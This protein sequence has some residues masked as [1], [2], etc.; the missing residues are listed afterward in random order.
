MASFQVSEN[1]AD[2]R[3]VR[4]Q[5]CQAGNRPRCSRLRGCH[6]LRA[7]R[8]KLWAEARIP[9]VLVTV[10]LQ[11]TSLAIS[12]PLSLSTKLIYATLV[13]VMC[14]GALRSRQSAHAG[15]EIC[16]TPILGLCCRSPGLPRTTTQ[17]CR[18]PLAA[19]ICRVR[20]SY[21][22]GSTNEKDML[23]CADVQ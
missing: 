5:W 6:L 9:L 1:R 20:V 15:L 22:L 21:R 10:P 18:V 8:F 19:A 17:I 2:V 14:L 23:A 4:S 7:L 3:R 13:L 11:L 12:T 16:L